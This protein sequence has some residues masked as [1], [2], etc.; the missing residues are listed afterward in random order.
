MKRQAKRSFSS[1][2]EPFISFPFHEETCWHRI[3]ANDMQKPLLLIN[4]LL[5][6]TASLLCQGLQRVQRKLSEGLSASRKL[7]SSESFTISWT[8]PDSLNR[9]PQ[10]DNCRKFLHAMT[11]HNLTRKLWC[12][13]ELP[14]WGWSGREEEESWREFV[15][16]AQWHVNL[17]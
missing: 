13:R 1:A 6:C 7:C 10:I 3:K 14:R 5:A 17:L 4:S 8:H 15:S 16:S 11:R 2:V 12:K 9:F